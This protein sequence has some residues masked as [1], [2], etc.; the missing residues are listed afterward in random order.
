MTVTWELYQ[1]RQG[2]DLKQS[3]WTE[4]ETS[5]TELEELPEYRKWEYKTFAEKGV[6]A[7]QIGETVIILSSK[8][9]FLQNNVF[10]FGYIKELAYLCNR[11]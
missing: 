7:T 9:I 8:Y 2:A 3:L 4:N 6:E 10:L 5:K 11:K 1:G